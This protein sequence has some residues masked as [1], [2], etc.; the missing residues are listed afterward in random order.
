MARRLILLL[1]KPGM[2]HIWGRSA[3]EKSLSPI[4]ASFVA[5]GILGIH[6]RPS[7]ADSDTD[8]VLAALS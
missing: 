2:L 7:S 4:D 6:L 5:S 1:T 3:A 8:D